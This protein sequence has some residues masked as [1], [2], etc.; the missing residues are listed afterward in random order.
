MLSMDVNYKI[1]RDENEL[2]KF[3]TGLVTGQTYGGGIIFYL[4]D[5]GTHGLIAQ[6][7][8]LGVTSWGCSGTPITGADG[9][10]I[11][12]GLQNTI[13]IVNGCSTVGIAAR[14]CADSTVNG[15]TDW[16]LPS[17]AEVDQM[18][19]KRF[20]I[21]GFWNTQP[22]WSSTEANSISAWVRAF[23][24]PYSWTPHDKD[25]LAYVRAI[26]KF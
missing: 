15:Y 10:G 19:T 23:Y 14:L 3:G 12:D 16:Y 1:N 17:T 24:A 2:I 9:Q 13:D 21:G 7:S 26:R 18:F 6:T 5:N 25:A 22:Y 11:G 4:W 8:D 20:V